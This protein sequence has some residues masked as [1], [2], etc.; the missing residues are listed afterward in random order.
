M[1]HETVPVQV[2]ADVDK[3]IADLVMY[4]NTIPG[5]RTDASCQGTIGEGGPAPYPA[6]VMC[7]WELEAY[8]R[9]KAEFDIVFPVDCNETWGEVRPREGWSVHVAT[10]VGPSD[11][12][13]VLREA[14]GTVIVENLERPLKRATWFACR[15]CNGA[16]ETHDTIGH[17][18]RCWVP[19]AQNIVA[20]RAA[21][22]EGK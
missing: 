15:A 20:S 9:L 18:S 11:A 12:I 7:H 10:G 21:L 17:T 14:L 2:W 8:E 5:V 1:I 6:H 13:G 19:R 16:G 3:G 22:G 4:L